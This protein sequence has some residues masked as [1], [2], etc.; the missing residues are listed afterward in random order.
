MIKLSARLD[1]IRDESLLSLILRTA[2]E[3]CLT[4][5]NMAQL[6]GVKTGGI[7]PFL[8][9]RKWIDSLSVLLSTSHEEIERRM[10]LPVS[11]TTRS[12]ADEKAM[13]RSYFTNVRVLN[14]PVRSVAHSFF[15]S[16][17]N[18]EDLYFASRRFAPG[19][20]SAGGFHRALW[21]ID[22]IFACQETGEMLQETCTFCGKKPTWRTKGVT[23]CVCNTDLRSRKIIPIPPDLRVL[24]SFLHNLIS[25]CHEAQQQC[26]S[27]LPAALNNLGASILVDLMITVGHLARR[28]SPGAKAALKGLDADRKL[29]LM[30]LGYRCLPEWPERIL[31]LIDAALHNVASG[32]FQQHLSLGRIFPLVERAEYS[33]TKSILLPIAMGVWGGSLSVTSL[34]S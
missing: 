19:A 21:D 5:D 29:G 26:R 30:L 10:Y 32:T 25:P 6:V 31:P 17:V 11:D 12:S 24:S 23:R 9:D 22:F 28:Y 1:P 16:S 7:V 34:A 2:E 27:Q 15:G 3:N 33:E 8:F 13:S 4:S 18:R 20:L 14:L